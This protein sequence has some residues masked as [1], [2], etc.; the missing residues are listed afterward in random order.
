MPPLP[1]GGQARSW[2]LVVPEGLYLPDRF[3]RGVLVRL[4]ATFRA[5]RDEVPL[6]EAVRPLV[7]WAGEFVSAEVRATEA[8]QWATHVQL[9]RLARSLTRFR[10]VNGVDPEHLTDLFPAPQMAAPVFPLSACDRQFAVMTRSGAG[11]LTLR[12]KLPLTPFPRRTKDWSWHTVLLP[13]P[14]FRRELQDWCL[15]DLTLSAG[16]VLFRAASKLPQVATLDR[17][18]VV[19]VDWSPSSLLASRPDPV[20]QVQWAVLDVQQETL[21]RKRV[22]LGRALAWQGA[23]QL[24]DLARRSGASLIAFEDLRDLDTQGRGAFQNNRSSQSVRGVLYACTEQAA[25]RYGIEVVQV[26]ARG[27]S[28]QC[29]GCHGL[30]KRPDGYDSAACEACGLTGN[31]DVV[32]CV[33]I[34]KRA[35]LGREQISRP[36]G[37]PACKWCCMKRFRSGWGSR[38]SPGGRRNGRPEAGSFRRAGF[39]QTELD[40]EFRT[41]VTRFFLHE[42]RCGVRWSARH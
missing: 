8:G 2:T 16:K 14:A 21:S 38:S 30:V 9:D 29:P 37:R 35:L 26:P 20:T 18:A 7:D 40:S 10:K 1:S 23:N 24:V 34:A 36:R 3:K 22:R 11:D 25:S 6:M 42:C 19:G 13:I 39:G 4:M 12:I 5:R 15:P 33:N 32:A 31:R 41:N 27:T 17:P 28:A